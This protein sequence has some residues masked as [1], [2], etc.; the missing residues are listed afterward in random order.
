MR[1]DNNGF[2]NKSA[3]GTSSAAGTTNGMGAR[4]GIRSDAPGVGRDV[5]AV[6]DLCN[7]VTRLTGARDTER[8]ERIAQLAQQYRGGQYT[9]NA[10]QLGEALML[11]AF[12]G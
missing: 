4:N 1:I 8:S 3:R 10:G 9:V 5:A 6:S 2:E 12:E 7:L 11:N